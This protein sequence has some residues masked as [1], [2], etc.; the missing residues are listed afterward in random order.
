MRL[1]ARGMAPAA[2]A[3]PAFWRGLSPIVTGLCCRFDARRSPA[4]LFLT[5]SRTFAAARS[6]VPR[7]L[8]GDSNSGACSLY[9]ERSRRP[10][11]RIVASLPTPY[12]FLRCSS[13]WCSPSWSRQKRINA[14]TFINAISTAQ[15]PRPDSSPSLSVGCVAY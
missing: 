7:V 2:A 9:V 6:V 11:L 3:T 8:G 15:L 13:L 4:L 14:D 5:V 10:I 1:T 12:S